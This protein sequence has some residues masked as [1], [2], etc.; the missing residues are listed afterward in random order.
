MVGTPAVAA[1]EF[2]MGLMRIGS[3][4]I[5]ACAAVAVLSA[6]PALA[7]NSASTA[8][9]IS[10][11]VWEPNE[12]NPERIQIHGVF[13]VRMVLYSGTE[14][15]DCEPKGDAP[16][17]ITAPTEGYIYYD[18]DPSVEFLGQPITLE[19]C[20]SEWQAIVATN[21]L[22]GC[23]ALGNNLVENVRAPGTPPTDPDP[24]LRIHFGPS[25]FGTPYWLKCNEFEG[26]TPP[27]CGDGIHHTGEWCDGNCMPDGQAC[28]PEAIWT[29]GCGRPELVGSA[30]T[31]DRHCTT[32]TNLATACVNDDGCCSHHTNVKYCDGGCCIPP[33]AEF[34]SGCKDSDCAPGAV[35][36]ISCHTSAD[37]GPNKI[38]VH[39]NTIASYCADKGTTTPAEDIAPPDSDTGTPPAEDLGT[40]ELTDTAVAEEPDTVASEE[41][42]TGVSDPPAAPKKSSGGCITG[43]NTGTPVLLLLLAGT[44]MFWRSRRKRA[45]PS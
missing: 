30:D 32:T 31:C 7:D 40:P 3:R 43:P 42:D 9:Q 17:C 36:E 37:C 25:K 44:F 38:C 6:T 16:W 34:S 22:Q 13:R 11:V 5:I 28:D 29:C 15:S 14:Y 39:P 33:D 23:V 35:I 19:E 10:H 2:N 4:W 21:D 18:C 1:G 24:Y 26:A 8:A 27:V 41:P 12:E 45:L 20:V